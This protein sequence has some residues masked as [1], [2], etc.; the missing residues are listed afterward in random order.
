MK[1]G[2]LV[3]VLTILAV[4]TSTSAAVAHGDEQQGPKHSSEISPRVQRQLN[5]VRLATARFHRVSAAER[6][7]YVEF[8]ECFDDATR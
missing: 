3:A 1:R 8:L 2:S 7:G 4:L 6:A 5:R